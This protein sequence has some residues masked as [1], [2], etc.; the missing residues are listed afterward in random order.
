MLSCNFFIKSFLLLISSLNIIADLDLL[1][2]LS[3][4]YFVSSFGFKLYQPVLYL[5]LQLFLFV[6]AEAFPK[7][8]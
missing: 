5:D 4:I 2:D 7:A 8:E 6:F 3:S 1:S